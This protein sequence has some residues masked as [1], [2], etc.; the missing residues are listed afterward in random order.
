MIVPNNQNAIGKSLLS[1]G[2]KLPCVAHFHLSFYEL[3]F[4]IYVSLTWL[5]RT[6][7]IHISGNPGLEL[8][9][10]LLQ[11]VALA[12]LAL[13]MLKQRHTVCEWLA[14]AA[15]V[16]AAFLIWRTSKEGWY[17]W[18]AAFIVCGR[19]ASLKRLALIL[20]LSISTVVSLSVVL[21]LAGLVDNVILDR[22]G[23]S[24]R[25]SMGFAH[26]NFFA[27]AL[28]VIAAC[29]VTL[30]YRKSAAVVLLPLVALLLPCLFVAG[31]RASSLCLLL[32]GLL[33]IAFRVAERFNACTLITLISLVVFVAM[34]LVSVWFAAFYNP[35]NPLN[36]MLDSF[37]SGRLRLANLYYEVHHPALFGYSYPDGPVQYVQNAGGTEYN[38]LVDNLYAHILLRYG[39]LAFAMFIFTVVAFY[40]KAIRERYFGFL[41]LGMTLFLV[42]GFSESLGCRVECNFFLI[43]FS[44]LLYGFPLKR[45]EGFAENREQT[46]AGLTAVE[47][48]RSLHTRLGRAK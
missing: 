5:A 17:F 7:V 41:L 22:K 2:V 26:P 27:S 34:V 3:A 42:Y 39:L 21:S 36:A 48:I 12:L 47:L 45:A 11:L 40:I 19:D 37:L 1:H 13:T 29:L 32:V 44:T 25:Y 35:D 20:L 28:I 38:F 23:T 15:I 6:T 24:Y 16:V 43:S 8:V 9:E 4:F 31:S 30:N 18:T 46:E 33:Y 10:T 14:S